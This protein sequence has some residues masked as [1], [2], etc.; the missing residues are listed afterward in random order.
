[1]ENIK[2][3]LPG[4]VKK[5]FFFNLLYF[6]FFFSGG[7]FPRFEGHGGGNNLLTIRDF[8]KGLKLTFIVMIKRVSEHFSP[9][10]LILRSK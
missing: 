6:F 7:A 1:M 4:P 10:K 2:T 8:V 9:G 5:K 3:N